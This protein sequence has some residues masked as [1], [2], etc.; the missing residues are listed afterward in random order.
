MYTMVICIYIYETIFDHALRPN[1]GMCLYD[2]PITGPASDWPMD[3]REE[4]LFHVGNTFG[5]RNI[6]YQGA[7]AVR[8]T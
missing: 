2:F 8:K 5:E 7:K 1:C 6:L 3:F 4:L